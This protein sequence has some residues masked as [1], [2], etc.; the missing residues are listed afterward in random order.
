MAQELASD[1]ELMVRVAA[2]DRLAYD[3]LARRHLNRV[4]A[5]ARG[6]L[7]SQ[8]AA[9]DAAQDAFT[10]LWIYAPRWAEGKAAFTTWLYRIVVNCCHDHLRK[11][12]QDRNSLEIPEDLAE[13]GPDGEAIY[14]KRQQD[15]RVKAALQALPDRQRTAVLLCYFQGMTNP[16]AAA[17]MDMHVKALEGLLVRARKTLRGLLEEERARYG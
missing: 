6:M 13:N 8:T 10:R 12:R 5:I 3:A 4:Y 11:T 9:E 17:A 14:A 7:K 15:E 16:E 2:G 1:E